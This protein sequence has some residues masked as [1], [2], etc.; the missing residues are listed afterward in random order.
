M[1]QA[2]RTRLR[3]AIGRSNQL[4]ASS[5]QAA[6]GSGSS[7][8]YPSQLPGT[9][10]RLEHLPRSLHQPVNDDPSPVSRGHDCSLHELMCARPCCA[11]GLPE[12]GAEP[13][14]PAARKAK[15]IK[16][17][18][19]TEQRRP[20]NHT[21]YMK[22]TKQAHADL[23]ASATP[24][25]AVFA[26]TKGGKARPTDVAMR[27]AKSRTST[28]IVRSLLRAGGA[29]QQAEATRLA[30][31]RPELHAAAALLDLGGKEEDAA[32]H[33]AGQFG[34]M[35][36]QATAAAKP[37]ANVSADQTAFVECLHVAIAS[38]VRRDRLEYDSESASE[39]EEEPDEE[40][41]ELEASS[42]ED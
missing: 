21:S 36:K 22:R 2:T 33:M 8:E 40:S 19:S 11:A 16:P 1:V 4:C 17:A 3:R 41:D 38:A 6:H 14:E 25:S 12:A 9:L 24:S 42:D 31:R 28:P 18:A 5:S 30:L 29:E 15:R 10:R 34:N 32:M 20:W 23:D 37:R 26:L 13:A 35:R 7:Y 27:M 39:S